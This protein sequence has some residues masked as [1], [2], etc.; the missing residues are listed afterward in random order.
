M[1]PGVQKFVSV[2]GKIL[3]CV[4][5]Y[6]TIA[7]ELLSNVMKYTVFPDLG[8]LLSRVLQCVSAAMSRHYAALQAPCCFINIFTVI[9]S[10]C[11]ITEQYF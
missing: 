5:K 8:E 9:N 6:I 7:S 1:M 2:V 10:H 11:P 3:S 4:F